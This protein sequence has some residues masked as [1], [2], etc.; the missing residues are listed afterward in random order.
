MADLYSSYSRE[1]Y[2]TA[3][4]SRESNA[5]PPLPA[6][7]ASSPSNTTSSVDPHEYYRRREPSRRES[8]HA[9]AP[10]SSVGIE[11]EA[12]TLSMRLPHR[13]STAYSSPLVS[14]FSTRSEARTTPSPLSSRISNPKSS[15]QLASFAKARQSSLQDRIN[16]FEQ[17]RDH[18]PPLPVNSSIRNSSVT[19]SPANSSGPGSF[20]TRTPSNPKRSTNDT[21][22]RNSLSGSEKGRNSPVSPRR[23]KPA[24]ANTST[25]YIDT[26][27]PTE[28][29]GVN[30][31]ANNSSASQSMVDLNSERV[32]NI[33]KPLFGEVISPTNDP[34]YG[35]PVSRRRRGSEGSMHTPNPMFP[36]DTSPAC[37][38]LSPSSPTAAEKWYKGITQTLEG[39]DFNR[40]VPARPQGMHRRSRSD[41]SSSNPTIPFSSSLGRITIMSP[42]QEVVTPFVSPLATRRNSQSRIPVSTQRTSFTSDSGNSV[43]AVPQSTTVQT[44]HWKP[45]SKAINF[46]SKPRT[47]PKSPSPELQDVSNSTARTPT[48]RT[49]SHL[50]QSHNSSQNVPAYISETQPLKSPPLRNSRARQPVSTATTS[51]SRARAVERLTM[52]QS[53][54]SARDRRSKNLPELDGVDLAA[55]KK[56]IQRGYTL[57]VRNNEQKKAAEAERKRRSM[58]F[59]SQLKHTGM[60]FRQQVNIEEGPSV[61]V[62]DPGN[63]T[64]EVENN[65]QLVTS[66]LESNKPEFGLSIDT[67]SVADRLLLDLDQGDSPTLGVANRFSGGLDHRDETPSPSSE[68]EPLSAITA[69]TAETFFDNDPQEG[70]PSFNTYDRTLLSTVFNL[71]EPSPDEHKALSPTTAR[72]FQRMESSLSD[73]DDEGSIQIMLGVTPVTETSHAD[74]TMPGRDVEESEGR[75]L[76]RWSADSW[77][78]SSPSRDEQAGDRGSETPLESIDEH[79]LPG[80]MNHVSL[81]TTVNSYNT[82]PWSPDSERSILSGRTTIDSEFYNPINRLLDSYH[83]QLSPEEFRD[84]EQRMLKHSPNLARAGGYDAK[85]VTQLFLQSRGQTQYTQP[86]AGPELPRFSIETPEHPIATTTDL[87]RDRDQESEPEESIVESPQTDNDMESGGQQEQG[88]MTRESLEVAELLNSQRASLN[89]PDDWAN[90][91]PSMMDWIDRQALDTPTEEKPLPAPRNWIGGVLDVPAKSVD[92]AHTRDLSIGGHPQLPEIRRTESG[93]GIDIDINV[94]SPYEEKVSD[95]TTH[96]SALEK[97]SLARD[98]RLQHDDQA[99][100]NEK[101]SPV[102]PKASRRYQI[103]HTNSTSAPDVGNERNGMNGTLQHVTPVKPTASSSE[104]TSR[105]FDRPS[106]DGPVPSSNPGTRSTSPSRDQKRLI[107]RRHILKELLDTESSYGQDMNVIKDLYQGTTDG[108]LGAEDVRVLFGNT[109]QIVDFTTT[110]LSA[111]KLSIKSVYVLPKKPRWKSKRDSEATTASGNT[112]DQSSILG[113]EL[114]DDEKDRKTFVGDVFNNFI[115]QMEKVYGEYLRN[116]DAANTKLAALLQVTRIRLWLKECSTW[117]HD[118]TDAWSLDSLLVKPVQRILKYPL[119]L[120]ELL[121]VTPQDHPDYAMVCY[122]E[123]EMRAVSRRINDL[124]KRSDIV[125]NIGKDRKR[126]DYDGRIG[127]KG[128]ARRTEK[129]KQQVGLSDTVRDI[130]YDKVAEDFAMHAFRLNETKEHCKKYTEDVYTFTKSFNDFIHAIEAHMDVGQSAYPEKESKWRQFRMSMRDVSSTALPD[131]VAAVEKNVIKPMITALEMSKGTLKLME[132]RRKG[133]LDFAKYKAMRERGDKVDKKTTEAADTFTALNDALKD[134]LPKLYDLTAQLVQ[135]CLKSF[136]QLQRKWQTV[137]KRKLGQVLDGPEPAKDQSLVDYINAMVVA[138][139][140]DYDVYESQVLSLGICNGSAIL[141]TANLMNFLA[142]IA[143][144]SSDGTTSPRRPSTTD[145]HTRGYSNSTKVSPMLPQQDF[146]L[147]QTDNY[148]TLNPGS[149]VHYQQGRGYR[150][151]ASSGASARGPSTP[152]MI[153]GTWRGYSN[154][155]TPVNSH[156]TRPSTSTGKSTDPP[157]LPRAS[158]ES[159]S[160]GRYSG[161]SHSAHR[162]SSSSTYYSTSKGA[163]ARPSS[164]SEQQSSIFSSAMPLSDS[165]PQQSPVG[166]IYDE[167]KPTVLFLAASVYEFN[168]DRSRREAGYPYLTYGAGEIFDVVAEKGELWLAKNQDDATNT[169]GWIWNKHFAKLAS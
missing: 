74:Q 106:Y 169:L 162:P 22:G 122:V 113:V 163:Q 140:G 128:F 110:F 63:A 155:T 11:M 166:N 65:T 12:G 76:N 31:V 101:S 146:S 35:I 92:R 96:P 103:S 15:P 78:S 123:S 67:T 17:Q 32:E 69:G 80:G 157:L 50:S 104:S 151:R 133:V 121:D 107:R 95:P 39:I 160:F 132:K 5:L 137:W 49:P 120:K 145:L 24:V 129:F 66:A 138:F 43:V 114:S 61:I 72:M 148:G 10:T 18:M 14:T 149:G 99:H 25:T 51:A 26:R 139:R 111:L 53:I 52:R 150:L 154:S 91:S 83:E 2:E 30:R 3:D 7:P 70:E 20:R 143:E 9:Y 36:Q 147:R 117:A 131:H 47:V 44:D 33:R 125:G 153:N 34:G 108:V 87:S 29:H 16:K 71:R 168:I 93:L 81:P 59:D 75:K 82:M 64:L 28:Q 167:R 130:A 89:R 115:P 86:N 118:L 27:K 13:S 142:P 90:T 164:P 84:F 62:E 135:S 54:G 56:E 97:V 41:F 23:R 6:Y 116:H 102:T 152:D 55:R 144:P 58:V 165:P 45:P 159:A 8:R 109:D 19:A 42:T 100:T 77:P 46:F 161:D 48:R 105:A 119:L 141:E 21:T 60:D 4:A 85:K 136:I 127:L 57:A 98:A 1:D 134:E 40:P 38:R 37:S 79:E 112:D 124:K 126:K 73:R 158:V 94:E 88:E 156:H 68:P